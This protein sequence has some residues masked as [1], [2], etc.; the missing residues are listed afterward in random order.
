VIDRH[1]NQN[2]QVKHAGIQMTE[3]ILEDGRRPRAA[4]LDLRRRLTGYSE[5]GEETHLVRSAVDRKCPPVSLSFLYLAL[6]LLTHIK[7]LISISLN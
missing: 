3:A 1:A 7:V 5:D 6:L 2:V 4:K